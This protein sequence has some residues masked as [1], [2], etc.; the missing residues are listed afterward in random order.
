MVATRHVPSEFTSAALGE[1]DLH[2]QLTKEG[3]RTW[4]ART[5]A[6]RGWKRGLNDMQ[7]GKD[8]INAT[9]MGSAAKG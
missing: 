3:S 6:V 4:N 1:K 8:K 9:T 5:Q 7:T 2:T